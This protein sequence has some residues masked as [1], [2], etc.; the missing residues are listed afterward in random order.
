MNPQSAQV[1]ARDIILQQAEETGQP[2]VVRT[3]P[4]HSVAQFLGVVMDAQVAAGVAA[5]VFEPQE[6]SFFDFGMGQKIPLGPSDIKAEMSET[7]LDKARST[8]G[9][10]SMA[11]EGLSFSR[12]GYRC[13]YA[14]GTAGWGV[15]PVSDALKA[16]MLGEA[17]VVDPFGI[18]TPPELQSPFQLQDSL[19]QSLIKVASVSIDLDT[20]RPYD[21][22]LLDVMPCSNG[23]SYLN[24]NGVP[25][26]ESRFDI[27]EG[28]LWS[29]DGKADADIR[30]RVKL[31]RR[32][33]M[34]IHL[35]TLPGGQAA[36]APTNVHVVTMLRL[37][38]L[39]TGPIARN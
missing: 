26:K 24:A 8:N 27:P 25:S 10:T 20:S 31:H 37:H 36:T 9:A 14:S 23:T 21:L 6:V 5:V 15:A 1:T 7:N 33:V 35:V 30:V 39:S 2:Y 38:G 19:L 3:S 29:P 34:P 4:L 16:A 32:V 28:I 18:I 12:V 17:V 13:Q 22:G 11:I